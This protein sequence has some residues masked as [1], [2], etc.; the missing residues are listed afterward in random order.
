[1]GS[2]RLR[3]KSLDRNSFNS[4]DWFNA[5]RWDPAQ[6]NGFGLGLPPAEDNEDKWPWARPLLAD[7]ALVPPAEVIDM[8]AERYRELLR[9]RRSSPVFG[10]P[11]ADEVERRLTFPLGG[12]AE[13]PGVIVMCV[14]GTGLDPRWQQV[15]VVFNATDAETAH[16]VPA[17]AGMELRLH[18]D[19]TASA[20][21]VLRTATTDPATGTLTVPA[22][23]VAVYV[24]D[25][26]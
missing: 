19:L 17:L 8:C 11:T 12:P 3:S 9:I 26:G 5:I 10:L 18:P 7:P 24:A 25:L 15:V 1:M 6:G 4:G 14:D 23:S 16:T 21:P 22:R 13:T 20:D 2:E